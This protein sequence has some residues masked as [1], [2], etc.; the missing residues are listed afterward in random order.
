MQNGAHARLDFI[1][2]MEY[3]F[4]ELMTIN[5]DRSSEETVQQQIT[6]RYNALKSRLTL[7]Q[8]RLQ[9]VNNLVRIKNPSL[10]LQLQKP[11]QG[12]HEG[13]GAV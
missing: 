11:R 9:E 8:A 1:Q 6:F 3:K 5:F 4:V 10:L 2:N 12:A 7:M 13:R